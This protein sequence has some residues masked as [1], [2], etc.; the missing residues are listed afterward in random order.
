MQEGLVGKE[1]PNA[2]QLFILP[3]DSTE[4][5]LMET[6]PLSHDPLGYFTVVAV[7]VCV[8]EFGRYTVPQYKLL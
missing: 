4:I 2:S 6:Y 1:D 8:C 5:K 3:N 7:F